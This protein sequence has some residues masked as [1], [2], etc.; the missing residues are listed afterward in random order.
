MHMYHRFIY[1]GENIWHLALSVVLGMDHGDY[2][3]LESEHVGMDNGGL[4][5]F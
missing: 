4:L 2:C 5:Y 3:I 1:R